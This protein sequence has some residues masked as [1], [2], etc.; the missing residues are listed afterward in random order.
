MSDT[1]TPPRLDEGSI[2][3]G[4][5]RVDDVVRASEHNFVAA[6]GGDIHDYQR[7]P[8]RVADRTI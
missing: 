8:V 6:I 3:D 1:A 7:Y 5:I 4:A 2:E